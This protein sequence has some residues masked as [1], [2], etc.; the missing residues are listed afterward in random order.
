[1]NN[2][3][4]LQILTVDEVTMMYLFRHDEAVSETIGAILLVSIVVIAVAIV[5]AILWSQPPPQK[6]PAFS[7]SITNASCSVILAHSGGET[8]TNTTISI[9][10]D[11]ADQTANFIKQGSAGPWVTWGIGETLVFTPSIPCILAPQRVDIVYAY[12]TGR[13][14]L[15]SV[16]LENPLSANFTPRPPVPPAIADFT[17]NTTSGL[18]P[19]AV[20]F[21][22]TSTG[23]P[24]AW[25]WTFGDGGTSTLQ[26]PAHTYSGANSYTVS[27]TVD[28]GTGVGTNTKVRTNY[29]TVYAPPLVANFISNITTGSAPLTVPFIDIST[30]SPVTW[31]WIFGDIG[32]GNTSTA[33]NPSHTYATHGRYTVN[34]TVTNASGGRSS[35]NR[36]SYIT[37]TP[38]PPWYSCS[39]SYR[40][41]ITI[42][43]SGVSGTQTNF[44]VLINLTSDSDL[45]NYAR[46]DG[47]DILFT[48]SDGTTKIPHEIERYTSSSGG[49]TAWV[50][51]PSISSSANTT[52]Y[53]YYGN[54][55]SANQQDKTNVWT[56]SFRGVWHLNESSGNALDSTSYGTS[57]TYSGTYT[58]NVA[59]KVSRGTDFNT[60]GELDWGD[61][62]DGHLDFG[63]GS[64]TVS[65]WVNIDATVGS[66]SWP[67][68]I[69]KGIGSYTSGYDLEYEDDTNTMYFNIAD[70]STNEWG[71][72]SST[73]FSDDTWYYIV[74]VADRTG[75]RMHIYKNGVDTAGDTISPLGSID[76]TGHAAV[77]ADGGWGWFDG[78]LDEV[79]I[80]NT[81]RSAFWISTEYNN[82]N[83]PATF[84]SLGNQEQW[85]C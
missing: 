12:G 11:G 63:T 44:P 20:Q 57:G 41:N 62:A 50:K 6:I 39:W 75:N 71:M 32:A 27:L 79:R 31:A 76:T 82:Q 8:V 67:T 85:T 2:A 28:N 70:G 26:H 77:G 69:W 35:L 48:L 30:G 52:I 61:P 64:L 68:I 59:G 4:C 46:S 58:R 45:R 3:L 66:G 16:Y 23:P 83:S 34:L 40:K 78:I 49:L 37:V 25:N 42:D 15:S 73:T 17:S 24:L 10:I 1:M 65:A 38:N 36:T 22:D 19:L 5:G 84:Y 51:V 33:Q 80:S 60:N 54:A 74:G 18:G 53:M 47:Y 13:N 9:I 81:A 14:L 7:A 29:I 55:A 21:T 72:S 43:K 56:N